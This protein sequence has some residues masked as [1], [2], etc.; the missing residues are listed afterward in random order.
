MAAAGGAVQAPTLLWHSRPLHYVDVTLSL[1]ELC[2][3]RPWEGGASAEAGMFTDPAA[4]TQQ[5][6]VASGATGMWCNGLSVA[7]TW[8]QAVLPFIP[9]L[10]L[11]SVI[12]SLCLMC[13]QPQ[14]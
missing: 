1:A 9:G 4:A 6:V 10:V 5:L 7:H 8:G 12:A 11:K 14:Q 13:W 2:G 3:A